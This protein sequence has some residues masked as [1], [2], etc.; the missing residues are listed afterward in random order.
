MSGRRADIRETAGRRA[1]RSAG[2]STAAGGGSRAHIGGQRHRLNVAAGFEPVR[3]TFV[4]EICGAVRAVP[5]GGRDMT[6]SANI[7]TALKPMPC[8]PAK[9]G[10]LAL[11]VGIAGVNA[12]LA[13]GNIGPVSSGGNI[14]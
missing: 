6:C 13:G 3:H 8:A 9:P 5:Y 7:T 10:R 14:V 4:H 2:R 1:R 12:R 11:P